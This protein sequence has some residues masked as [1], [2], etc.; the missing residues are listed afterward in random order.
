MKYQLLILTA[1]LLVAASPQLLVEIQDETITSYEITTGV[2]PT[3]TTGDWTLELLDSNGRVVSQTRYHNDIILPD[4][5]TEALE[6]VH[7]PI[8]APPAARSISLRD[9]DGER[10]SA[11]E[12]MPRCGDGRCDP[13]ERGICPADCAESTTELQTQ[14]ANQAPASNGLSTASWLTIGAAGL[15][16]LVLI[17]VLVHL[18]RKKEN[19]VQ[20]H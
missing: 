6:E 2:D 5:T 16:I 13:S 12:I 10:V 9:P 19:P 11:Y 7:I 17:L 4:G 20:I 8:H 15:L 3:R 14:Q 18:N 1:L